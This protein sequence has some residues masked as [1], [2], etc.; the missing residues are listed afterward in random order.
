MVLI[1]GVF[2]ALNAGYSHFTPWYCFCAAGH[3]FKAAP[4]VK[5][6]KCA[7]CQT[8]IGQLAGGYGYQCERM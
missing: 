8:N 1:G 4:F 5:L 3:N 2:F 7:V 6:M